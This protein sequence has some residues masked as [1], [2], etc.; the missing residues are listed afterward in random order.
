[1]EVFMSIVLLG[2]MDRLERHYLNEASRRGISLKVF[3]KPAKG[4]GKKI[5]KVDAIVLFTDKVA[6]SLR[7]EIVNFARAN[8][9]PCFM[10]HSCGICTLRKCLDC[11]K[12]FGQKGVL[13]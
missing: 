6:H 4:I 3:T 12:N 9:I 10:Y 2:G 7:Y 8:G 13:A 1:M 11:L 5:G